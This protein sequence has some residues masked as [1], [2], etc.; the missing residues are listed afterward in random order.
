MLNT[1]WNHAITYTYM[2]HRFMTEME[3]SDWYLSGP[4][5]PVR[6]AQMDRSRHAMFIFGLIV[7]IVFSLAAKSSGNFSAN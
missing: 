4:Y 3:H 6:T 2:A 7:S 1:P 5:F